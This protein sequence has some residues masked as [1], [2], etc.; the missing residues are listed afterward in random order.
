MKT[1]GFANELNSQGKCMHY[2]SEQTSHTRPMMVSLASFAEL[3]AFGFDAHLW[4][5]QLCFPLLGHLGKCVGKCEWQPDSIPYPSGSKQLIN[6]P[7]VWLLFDQTRLRFLGAGHT[8]CTL[9]VC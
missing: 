2:R 1:R 6:L 9:S 8:V 7:G 4:F 3:L 5:F